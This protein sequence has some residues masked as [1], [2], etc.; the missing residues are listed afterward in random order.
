MMRQLSWLARLVWSCVVSERYTLYRV[1]QRHTLTC[2]TRFALVDV[3][4][5][6]YL[7]LRVPTEE[8]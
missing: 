8:V 2:A 5:V 1:S 6:L 7:L 3:T 4:F